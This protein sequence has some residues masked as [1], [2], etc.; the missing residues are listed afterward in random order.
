VKRSTVSVSVGALKLLLTAFVALVHGCSPRPWLSVAKTGSL[1]DLQ[2][3]VEVAASRH[4]FNESRVL[5]LAQVVAQREI[6]TA[7]DK[8]ASDRLLGLQACAS[9]L[10]WPLEHRSK[11]KDDVAAAAALLLIDAGLRDPTEGAVS[12]ATSGE[13]AWRAVAIRS[14][15]SPELRLLV[16][17]ALIDADPRVRR[18]ALRTILVEPL[19]S[20]G[21]ALVEVARLDPDES[22][23][24]MALLAIGET[25]D[26]N[27]LLA[28]HDLWDEMIE[29]SRLAFLQALYAPASRARGGAQI[30]AR[31]MQ[32]SDSLEG[33]VAASLLC[34]EPPQT[35]QYAVGRLLRALHQ[36]TTSERLVAL[37]S[38]P[39]NEADVQ[40]EIHQMALKGAPY[41]RVASLELWLKSG[42]DL[43]VAQER[44]E[45]IAASHDVD[46]FEASRILALR[47]DLSSIFRLEGRL[48]APLAEERIAV[49][50]PLIRL[51][52]WDA[53]AQAL[54]DDHPAVRLAT[55]CN[56]LSE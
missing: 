53:V 26:P 42:R 12:H 29:P 31:V 46:A 2:R 11:G 8:G 34:H 18:A 28:A 56:V 14:A 27:S 38:L 9:E 32:S 48:T 15:V 17:S 51:K 23:R 19:T 45:T 55:A 33:V 54:T 36:G 43:A 50:R 5:Q 1:T 40:T 47:G 7:A 35:S 20:D 25:G 39:P 49:V 22:I 30:L 3:F 6:A 24:Q 52:R 13:G 37:A 10:Y 21:A 16:Y 4:Q 44:I 41:L